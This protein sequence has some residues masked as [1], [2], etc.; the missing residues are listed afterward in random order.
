M[1]QKGNESEFLPKKEKI[2]KTPC[3]LDRFVQKIG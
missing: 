1:K 3:I 2:L